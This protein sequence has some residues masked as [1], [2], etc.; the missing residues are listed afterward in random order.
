[1]PYNR[2]GREGD[3]DLRPNTRLGTGR[4][5]SYTWTRHICQTVVPVDPLV[6]HPIAR[7]LLGC[8]VLT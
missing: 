1:M 8:G 3:G 5:R 4:V 2:Y 7:V 6:Q